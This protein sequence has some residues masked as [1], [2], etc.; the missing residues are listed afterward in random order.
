[1]SALLKTQVT[2]YLNGNS[3]AG[4]LVDPTLKSHKDEELNVICQ[5][6]LDCVSPD[7]T[8]RPTM[9]EVTSKLRGIMPIS[10][11]TATPKP[12]PLWWAELEILAV[13]A[14]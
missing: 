14:S 12:S 1:M 8:N 11:E 9:K 13:G 3:G 5:V 4:S 2:E 10:P 7:P 6:I